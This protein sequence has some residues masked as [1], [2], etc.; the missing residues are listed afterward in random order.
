MK[1]VK[2]G[3][4]EAMPC[5][6]LLTRPS[7]TLSTHASVGI[8]SLKLFEMGAASRGVEAAQGEAGWSQADTKSAQPLARVLRAGKPRTER[9]APR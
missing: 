2:S 9:P 5:P 7:G 4:E 1:Q 6:L 3:G 8:T